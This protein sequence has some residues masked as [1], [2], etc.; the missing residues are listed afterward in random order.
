MSILPVIRE[1]SRDTNAQAPAPP[2]ATPKVVRI[3]QRQ[4]QAGRIWP[5]PQ[6]RT[7]Q[8]EG[9]QP[10]QTQA[11]S[12]LPL[13]SVGLAPAGTVPQRGPGLAAKRMMDVTIAAT[14]LVVLSPILIMVAALVRLRMGGGILYSQPRVGRDGLLFD[15]YKFRTMVPGGEALLQAYFIDNPDAKAEWDESQKLKNDPRV[16]RIGRWLRKS[17]LDELPQLFN[18]LIGDMSCV[19]P[20]PVVEEE[21]KRY[22]AHAADYTSVRPGLTGIWQIS[23]RNRLSY[24]ERVKLDVDYIRQWSLKRDIA[25][26]IMTIPAVAKFDQT[27]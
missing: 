25:I 2:A 1:S 22:G 11:N 10:S 19:G 14:A 20:R 9:A 16:T 4:A 8:T 23:G 21:L 24:P 13:V 18:V 7:F 15:C 26:L 6:E 17:S 12:S 27:A 3:P 5:I